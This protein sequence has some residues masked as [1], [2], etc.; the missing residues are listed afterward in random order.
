MVQEMYKIPAFSPVTIAPVDVKIALLS[1]IAQWTLTN[2]AA[3]KK[4]SVFT[5]MVSKP[6]QD[7]EEV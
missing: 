2:A 1:T 7:L 5:R 4:T 3:F 6:G